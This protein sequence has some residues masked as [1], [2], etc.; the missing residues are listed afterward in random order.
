M[1]TLFTTIFKILHDDIDS[2]VC[3]IPESEN[4]GKQFNYVHNIYGS[5]I[6]VFYHRT[7]TAA[8]HCLEEGWRR[9]RTGQN[10][11]AAS[12]KGLL[13]LGPA[14]H[15]N[16]GGSFKKKPRGLDPT[17]CNWSGVQPGCQDF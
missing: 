3:R 14:P 12:Y 4:L 13:I 17:R 8:P 9:V 11:P 6:S 7:A 16:H 15:W 1:C 5:C 10:E 2:N